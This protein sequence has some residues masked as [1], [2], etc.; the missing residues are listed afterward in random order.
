MEKLS[1]KNYTDK[2]SFEYVKE[3]YPKTY[4]QELEMSIRQIL[5]Y[6]KIKNAPA[7]K[8]LNFCL[9]LANSEVKRIYLL[10]AYYAIKTQQ[11]M[12]SNIDIIKRSIIH[13]K[14][15]YKIIENETGTEQYKALRRQAVSEEIKRLEKEKDHEFRKLEIDINLE[16]EGTV[17]NPNGSEQIL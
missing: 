16:V 11:T 6:S 7:L 13:V 9:R 2:Q 3:Y 17:I 15:Q 12:Q 14:K 5:G 1:I 4:H 8:S 10:A